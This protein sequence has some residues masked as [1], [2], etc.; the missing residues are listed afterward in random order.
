MEPEARAMRLGPR[1]AVR[2]PVVRVLC[3]TRRPWAMAPDG[4]GRPGVTSLACVTQVTQ[5]PVTSLPGPAECPL[6]TARGSALAGIGDS[7][8][9]AVQ[10][11][12]LSGR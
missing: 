7:E 1:G 2:M 3:D 11:A 5:P 10:T 8:S 12:R 6:H 4:T 9:D